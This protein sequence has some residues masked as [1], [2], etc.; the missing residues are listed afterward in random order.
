MYSFLPSEEQQMLQEVAHKYALSDVRPA[1]HEAEETRSLPDALIQKGWALGLTQAAI[2]EGFGGLGERSA[3]T[4]A[5]ALEE[6]AYG[7]LAVA[8][9]IAVPGLFALPITAMGSA[10]QKEKYLPKIAEGNWTPYTAALIERGFDFDPA[11]LASTAL[12]ESGHFVISG[13]KRWVPFADKAQAMIVYASLDGETQGFIVEGGSEGVTVGKREDL[14][15][16]NALPLYSVHLDR[17]RVPVANRLGGADGHKFE[18]LLTAMRI[19]NSSMALGLARASLD[20]SIEYAKDR[21]VLGSKVAQKQSIAF[22]LAEMATEIAAIRLLTWEAA[23][24]LDSG[25]D[26]AAHTAYLAASGAADMAMM[27]TDRGVQ[28]LGGHGYIREHPVELW[29]RNGRGFATFTG[30]SIV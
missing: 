18:P 2:P 28:I 26:D 20:Y 21:E 3:V 4:S 15:G 25:L 19:A 12:E 8:L 7:D 5:L 29:M 6:L 11:D 14:M 17:V 23:W 22:M 30:L 9:A 10:E 1:A 13:E 16:V 24:Q 27:V